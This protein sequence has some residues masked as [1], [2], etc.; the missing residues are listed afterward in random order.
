MCI[1]AKTFLARPDLKK[2]PARTGYGLV[3]AAQSIVE[4]NKSGNVK[5]PKVSVTVLDD[6]RGLVGLHDNLKLMICL[7]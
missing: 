5:T 6:L 2:P 3:D 7:W 1:Q 4:N